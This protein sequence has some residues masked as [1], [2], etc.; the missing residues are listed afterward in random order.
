MISAIEAK[1][2]DG[3]TGKDMTELLQMMENGDSHKN[4]HE[5]QRNI[6][7]ERKEVDAII[8]Q[9]RSA[10]S[11]GKERITALRKALETS[12]PGNQMGP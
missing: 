6:A 1:N 5:I 8:E 4:T 9:V 3:V 7:K 12:Q 2:T 11:A 10:V